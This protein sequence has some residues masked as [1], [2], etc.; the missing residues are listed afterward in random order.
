MSAS[1]KMDISA[2]PLTAPWAG[3]YGG[4][5]PFDEVKVGD[6][7]P[8]LDAAM[9]AQLAE[10]DAIAVNESPATFENTI[11][12]IERSG[13]AFQ[14]AHA[15][16]EVWSSTMNSPEFQKVEARMAAKLAAFQDRIVQ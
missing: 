1:A 5:P 4:V 2:H 14:R 10:L 9:A 15:I 7:E 12:A 8:A 13:A 3:V 11:A 16:F 6:F